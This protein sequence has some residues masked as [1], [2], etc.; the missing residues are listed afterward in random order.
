MEK[1]HYITMSMSFLS[2]KTYVEQDL[3]QNLQEGGKIK[4]LLVVIVGSRGM[5]KTTLLHCIG[6]KLERS[7]HM[8]CTNTLELKKKLKE[9][10]R[11]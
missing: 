3:V 9:C 7:E 6:E 8:D 4:G 1:S 5:G 11:A 10:L 2:G